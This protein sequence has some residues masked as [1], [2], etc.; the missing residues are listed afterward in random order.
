MWRSTPANGI[1]RAYMRVTNRESCSL[2]LLAFMLSSADMNNII[3]VKNLTKKYGSFTAVDNINFEVWQGETFGILGP[4]GAGKTTTL[5]M[6][7]GLKFISSGEVTLD[8]ND[9]KTQGQEVK[10]KI[11]VQL[12]SSSFFDG[13]NLIEL[14]ETFASLYNRRVDAQKLLS[15]VQLTEKANN[16]VKE[17]SG[18]Q[19]QR[20]SIAVALVN[21][22]KVLFLDEPTTGLDPQARHNLWELVKQIKSQ[23]KT[24]VLTTHYMEEA[25]VLC[26]RIAIMDHA[27]IVAL[28]TTEN[29]LK[30][31][32]VAS[33]IIFRTNRPFDMT[34]LKT[35]PGVDKASE[36]DGVYRLQCSNPQ[37]TLPSLFQR[38]QD[39]NLE[40]LDL[41]LTNPTLEDVFLTLTGHELRD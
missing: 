11:G 37:S 23:G 18:G 21:D 13:L 26:D 32:G 14:I 29:L 22:P 17:L 33:T 9:V 3:E 27:R 20:L 38:A 36:S 28:D 31:S 35:L 10:S 4:N 2:Q 30:Q 41:K 39:S 1:S 16:Q 6:I 34:Y 40:I 25:Q 12:Q 5:E 8:G 19:K 7:E 24:I 15:Q